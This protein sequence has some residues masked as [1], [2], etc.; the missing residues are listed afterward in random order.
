MK[1]AFRVVH[2]TLPLGEHPLSRLISF[3]ILQVFENLP[4]AL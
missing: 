3:M 2:I 4:V 1:E